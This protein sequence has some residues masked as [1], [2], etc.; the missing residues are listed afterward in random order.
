MLIP[1]FSSK[2][3]SPKKLS[4]KELIIN[5]VLL[6]IY[7]L[8]GM[9]VRSLISENYPIIIFITIMINTISL[10]F[11]ILTLLK[12]YSNF[13]DIGNGNQRIIT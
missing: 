4:K 13:I 6:C 12:L 1:I 7:A 11:F 5:Y 9:P 2:S 10:M 8:L 3:I